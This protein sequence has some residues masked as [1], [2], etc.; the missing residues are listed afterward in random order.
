MD[1]RAGDVFCGTDRDFEKQGGYGVSLFGTGGSGWHPNL[2]YES[3]FFVAKSCFYYSVKSAY[4]FDMRIFRNSG[5]FI[6]FLY[7][8]FEY[9]INILQK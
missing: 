4:G 7:P 5:G 6:A 1:N 9:D 3:I 2:R 8:D